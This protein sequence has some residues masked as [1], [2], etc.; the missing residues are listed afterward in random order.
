VNKQTTSSGNGT[1]YITATPIGNLGDWSM[2]AIETAKC[3]DMILCEDTR[4][5][6]KLLGHYGVHTPTMAYHEHNA[7]K[8]RPY[9]LQMLQQGKHVMLI[10]DAGT[11]LISDPGYRLVVELAQQ[12]IVCTPIPGASSVI[13]A[14]SVAGLP[15]DKFL[16]CG[17]LPNKTS[18]RHKEIMRYANLPVTL[19]YLES[20]NRLLAALTDLQDVLGNRQAVVTRELTKLHEEIAR[21]TLSE[22]IA[23]FSARK[24]VLGEI[25]LLVHGAQE[26]RA[27][28]ELT[29]DDIERMLR[30]AMAHG[31]TK[32]AANAIADATGLQRKTL[33]DMALRIK[34]SSS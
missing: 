18:L 26:L 5:S 17:F 11:P 29:Q 1:L 25:V 28:E 22:L 16:F 20:P 12:G 21:G 24:E 31:S 10:S 2:R 14:L 13:A 7:D 15:T 9:I 19:V 4:V 30:E 27:D 8:Q 34:Q 33:Y 23:L 6:R 3:V 32:D